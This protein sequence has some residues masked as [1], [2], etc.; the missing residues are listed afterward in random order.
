VPFPHVRALARLV[1][2]ASPSRSAFLTTCSASRSR[3]ICSSVIARSFEALLA[4]EH[5]R[6][7]AQ[8]LTSPLTPFL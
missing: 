2:T 3:T 5:A 7:I 6:A 1:R 8:H 4:S